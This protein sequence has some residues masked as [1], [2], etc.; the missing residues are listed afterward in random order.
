VGVLLNVINAFDS[1]GCVLQAIDTETFVAHEA[2]YEL[3]LA[4]NGARKQNDMQEELIWWGFDLAIEVREAVRY[5]T[6]F[7]KEASEGRY[8]LNPE[9]WGNVGAR[10]PF[11]NGDPFDEPAPGPYQLALEFAGLEPFGAEP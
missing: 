3:F 7:Y 8:K 9:E 6:A 5:D 10:A 2:V 11:E 4:Y 1:E